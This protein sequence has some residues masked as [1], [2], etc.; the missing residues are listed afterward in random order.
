MDA[1]IIGLIVAAVQ[2]VVTTVVGTIVGLI[3]KSRWEKGK[4]EKEELE[5][6]KE[7]KRAAGETQRCEIV[8]QSI[9]EEITTLG[10]EL[11]AQSI[12]RHDE[13]KGVVG[14]VKA[15]LALVKKGLQNDL[16]IDL[17][18][19]HDEYVEKGYATRDNKR[20]YDNLYFNYHNL[21]KNG[22][23]DGMHEKVMHLPEEK[24]AKPVAKKKTV[25]VEKKEK[26]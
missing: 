9:H 4:R 12:A 22:I 17:V 14:G 6:L 5:K 13:M 11:T 24:P 8:K 2:T 21:G 18:H 23:A 7:E 19:L 25:L 26:K 16:Y 1:W 15:D 20:D 3:I 10:K